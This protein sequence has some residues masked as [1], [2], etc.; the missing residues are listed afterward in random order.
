MS[1][2]VLLLLSP[3]IIVMAV[4]SVVGWMKVPSEARFRGRL[5]PTGT[6]FTVGKTTGFAMRLATAI[7]VYLGAAAM[8]GSGV[9]TGQAVL[10]GAVGLVVLLI[11][12]VS[13]IRRAS[14]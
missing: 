5:G 2:E 4:M 13:A 14:R 1:Q 3:L 9:S 12:Q 7:F 6:D 10:L 11:G 8:G